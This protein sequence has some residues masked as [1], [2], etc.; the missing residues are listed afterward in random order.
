MW[1]QNRGWF[2]APASQGIQNIEQKWR[3]GKTGFSPVVLITLIF[4]FL[5]LQQAH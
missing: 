4:N 5:P 2:D 1:R 3:R